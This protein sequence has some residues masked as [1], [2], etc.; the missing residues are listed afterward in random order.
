VFTPG[1]GPC[2]R[3]LF[4]EPTPAEMAPSCDEAGVLGVLPGVVGL[5]QAT[6]ALKVLLGAGETL[7]GRLLTY[8]ALGMTFRTFKVRRNPKCAVCGDNPTIRELS[9]L[10]WSCHVSAPPEP[11]AAR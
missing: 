11:A 7:R 10:E 9:D 8:D 2:Y 6:E 5:I 4:P 3:C 1:E